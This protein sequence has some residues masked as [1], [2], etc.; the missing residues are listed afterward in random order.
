[1][2]DAP[3]RIIISKQIIEMFIFYNSICEDYH[4]KRGIR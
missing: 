2:S 4:T 1:M 3:E